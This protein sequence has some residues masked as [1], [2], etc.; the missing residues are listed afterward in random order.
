MKRTIIAA[1]VASLVIIGVA[2]TAIAQSDTL[3][4]LLNPLVVKIQQTVPIELTVATAQE[5][6]SVITSTVPLTVGV[7][8]AITIQ[9]SQVVSLTADAGEPTVVVQALPVGE[10]L[11]DDSG[12]PY[13]LESMDGFVLSQLGSRAWNTDKFGLIGELRND[14]N[15]KGNVRINLTLYDAVGKILDVGSG[16]TAV[17][18]LAP[19]RS[20]A[21]ELFPGS[22][23]FADVA[24]YRIQ[25]TSY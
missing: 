14:G 1:A 23:D 18:P 25:I 9:G 7:D 10:E 3:A 15:H 21:F 4:G 13:T 24:R 5:D 16:F 17:Y 22:T 6:G 19:G 2:L 11:V 8:L 12:I 20:S